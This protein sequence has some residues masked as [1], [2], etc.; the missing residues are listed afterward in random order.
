MI[1][2]AQIGAIR[3]KSLDEES[4]FCGISYITNEVRD[5]LCRLPGF[6]CVKE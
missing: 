4:D 1:G 3:D 5:A 2:M 6:S